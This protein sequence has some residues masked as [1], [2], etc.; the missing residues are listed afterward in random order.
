MIQYG[1]RRL[2]LL[3]PPLMIQSRVFAHFSQDDSVPEFWPFLL[4]QPQMIQSG[5]FHGLVLITATLHR[6]R[7]VR[8]T[9]SMHHDGLIIIT[10]SLHH[11][12]LVL[13][14]ASLHHSRLVPVTALPHHNSLVLI[15]A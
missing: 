3:D 2:V 10:A 1:G 7:L 13:M 14:T 4:V 8:I 11:H 15:T 6:H 5:A 12:G 9:A